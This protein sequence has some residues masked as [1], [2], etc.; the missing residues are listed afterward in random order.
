VL[1]R[2]VRLRVSVE[3][4]TTLGWERF[5]GLDGGS[6]GIDRFGASAPA[7]VLFERLGVTVDTVVEH[8]RTLRG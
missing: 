5:V 1:P 3:A 8:T 4:G 2:S 6:V 7:E